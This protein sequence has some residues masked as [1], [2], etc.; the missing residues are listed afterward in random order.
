[1]AQTGLVIIGKLEKRWPS[2]HQA[3]TELMYILQDVSN[4]LEPALSL[5]QTDL[6]T[7]LHAKSFTAD[8]C[9]TVKYVSRVMFPLDS[10]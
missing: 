4:I 2:A 7:R 6:S 1:M 5:I 3:W 9:R 10:R 8:T